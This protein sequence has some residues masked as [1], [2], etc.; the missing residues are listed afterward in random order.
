MVDHAK[1]FSVCVEVIRSYQDETVG[2][3]QHLESF[4]SRHMHKVVSGK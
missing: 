1:L 3:E 2:V 4:L